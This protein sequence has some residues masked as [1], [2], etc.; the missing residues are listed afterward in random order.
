MIPRSRSAA[1]P[2]AAFSKPTVDVTCMESLW[3]LCVMVMDALEEADGN[4]DRANRFFC[5]FMRAKEHAESVDALV[6]EYV[7]L[8]GA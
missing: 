1:K 6:R 8:A 4:R 7:E 3:G 2:G 5:D